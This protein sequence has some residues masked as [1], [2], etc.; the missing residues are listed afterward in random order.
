M[1]REAAI[2]QVSHIEEVYQKLRR[3][4]HDPESISTP[5]DLTVTML[6][7][8]GEKHGVEGFGPGRQAELEAQVK[9]YETQQEKLT[10]ERTRLQGELSNFMYYG[11]S[12][13][14]MQEAEGEFEPKLD[15]AG[16][17]MEGRRHK[18]GKLKK[19][20]NDSKIG[21][22]LLTHL[23]LGD[24]I[25]KLATDSEIPMHLDRVER[26]LINLLSSIEQ[27]QRT[28]GRQQQRRPAAAAA[29]AAAEEAEEASA[30]EAVV[31]DVGDGGEG[32]ASPSEEKP[33]PPPPPQQPP[34]AP[35]PPSYPKPG[36]GG[37]GGGGRSAQA[38][39]IRVLT[40]Q[41]VEDLLDDMPEDEQEGYDDDGNELALTRRTKR[42]PEKGDG[43]KKKAGRKGGR[44]GHAT[45][46]P[47]Q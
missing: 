12:N 20:V 4:T 25:E 43:K 38:N 35:H 24:S 7:A 37:G 30:E 32:G 42:Q 39:N 5:K 31:A 13:Q 15:A 33:P 18:Y 21:M 26:H 1:E 44:H 14:M 22:A 16:K 47:L 41:E 29:A 19:L 17:L 6:T 11:S 34:L 23:T 46:A 9:D 45:A 8:L 36:G 28:S 2:T 40:A 3:A 10:E 27:A